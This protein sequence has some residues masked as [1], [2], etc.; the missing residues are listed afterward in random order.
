MKKGGRRVERRK[1]GYLT[2]SPWTTTS[3]ICFHGYS[4]NLTDNNWL[5][6]RLMFTCG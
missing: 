2:C 5:G 4:A 6:A 1:E 3:C